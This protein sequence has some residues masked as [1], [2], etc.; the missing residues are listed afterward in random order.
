MAEVGNING[1]NWFF[2]KKDFFPSFGLDWI[3][4]SYSHT[5]ST[6]TSR[7]NSGCFPRGKRVAINSAPPTFFFLFPACEYSCFPIPP[8]HNG[9]LLRKMEI[10]FFIVHIWWLWSV[11][12]YIYTGPTWHRERVCTWFWLDSAKRK[13]THRIPLGTRA[14]GVP[15]WS[16]IQ[17][18]PRLDCA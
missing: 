4:F 2:V 1:F 17:V 6:S 10:G 16:P 3:G 13:P 7:W 14:A 15:K 9:L 5:T 11:R 18:L 12:M 8:A